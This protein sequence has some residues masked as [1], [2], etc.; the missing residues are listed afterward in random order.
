MTAMPQH[1]QALSIANAV[2][3]AR[4]RLKNEVTNGERLAAEIIVTCPD[5]AYTMTVYELLR[6]QRQWGAHR[7]RKLLAVAQI[8][9]AKT[10]GSLT[11]RQ[12]TVL[13]DL[14]TWNVA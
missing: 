5:Q 7:S 11:D 3:T 12:R 13:Y 1:L 2:R 4:S 10:I 9:E 14:L 8:S 6:A